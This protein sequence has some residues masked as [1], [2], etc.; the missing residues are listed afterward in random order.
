MKL[1]ILD[2]DGVINEDSDA[3]IKSVEEWV[4]LPGSIQAIARL[5]KAGWTVAIATNQ[6]G[7]ARG[8]YTPATLQAMHARL[9]ELVAEQGGQVGLIVHCPHG[10]NDACACR[11]PK[12]G[13]LHEIG[14]HYGVALDNTWFVGDSASDLAA[15]VAVGAQPV[16]V[17]TGKGGRTA[18]GPIPA[19]TLQFADLA[20]VASALLNPITAS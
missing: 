19:G 9:R 14:N 11:K 17:E 15:A 18:A 20:A 8:Y 7:L 4:P 10:P 1:I 16:L 12:P 2:R 6:S 13:L 5:S 3:Y